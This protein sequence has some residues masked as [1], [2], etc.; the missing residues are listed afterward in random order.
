MTNAQKVDMLFYQLRYVDSDEFQ[1]QS[2]C[3]WRDGV[4]VYRQDNHLEIHPELVPTGYQFFY[5]T[6][7]PFLDIFKSYKFLSPTY[8][9]VFE[10]DSP[11]AAR[12]GTLPR[13]VVNHRAEFRV[14]PQTERVDGAACHVLERT[15]KDVLWVDPARNFAVRRRLYYQSPGVLLFE[16]RNSDYRAVGGGLWLPFKQVLVRYNLSTAPPEI[17]GK[18]RSVSTNVVRE[19]RLGGVAD[20]LFSVPVMEEG[21]VRDLVRGVTYRKFPKG[22]D[23]LKMSL[24]MSARVMPRDW[25]V[26]WADTLL[27]GFVAL[28]L[29][30]LSVQVR[31]LQKAQGT[32]GQSGVA[33]PAG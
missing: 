12:W 23:P 7:L 4:C 9:E 18:V 24:E 1:G 25:R 22:A 11:S 5:Y 6:D 8:T 26:V 10:A 2:W 32:S 19:A 29:A 28:G 27:C 33:A 16:S 20:G 30:S 15:G 21:T 31:A 3:C 14:R 13:S 17:R